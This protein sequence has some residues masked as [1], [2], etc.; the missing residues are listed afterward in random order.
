MPGNFGIESL[1][2]DEKEHPAPYP[3]P[4]RLLNYWQA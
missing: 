2:L 4:V 1:K 3:H